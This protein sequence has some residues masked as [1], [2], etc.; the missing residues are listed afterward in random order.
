[1]V[2][3]VDEGLVDLDL[4][5]LER[6]EVR[7]RR[8]AG[9]EV[10]D[11]D[12]EAEVAERL[13]DVLRASG[14][15][16]MRSDSVSS[17]SPS[18]DRCRPLPRIARSVPRARLSQLAGGEVHG[19]LEVA[20]RAEL[21]FQL[22]GARSRGLEHPRADGDDEARVLGDRDEVERRHRAEVG[23]IPPHQRLER[24]RRRPVS[25]V[26]DGL[27]VQ[28]E[29]V[30]L[31]RERADRVRAGRVDAVRSRISTSKIATASRPASFAWYIAVS[32]SRSRDSAV[33]ASS[34]VAMATP[35]L[36]DA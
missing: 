33:V 25:E 3:I 5:D 34:S 1:M 35:M 27:V 13:A 19:Q 4:V 18:G 14:F 15:W 28:H 20:A 10:V 22:R 31:E 8:V 30:V 12:P 21:R 23:R 6:A 26:D 32:A 17:R 7:Q 29:L 9:A 2:E 24:R 11:R 16:S 36:A